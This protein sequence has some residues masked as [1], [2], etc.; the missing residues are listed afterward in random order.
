MNILMINLN[1]IGQG[2]YWRAFHLGRHL[3][4]NGHKITIMATSRSRRINIAEF[5]KNGITFVETPDIF[6]GS[7]RSG[8]DPWNTWQRIHWVDQ[9]DFDLVHGFE[10]RPTVIYPAL[11]LAN[12]QKIPLI[13]DWADWFG[14]GGSVEERPN[15][16]IRSILRPM[17][18]YFEEHFRNQAVGTTVICETLREKARSL[19]I[20]PATILLLPNGSDTENRQMIPLA[21]ARQRT[22]IPGGDSIIGYIGSIFQRDADLMIKAFEIV[23]EAVPDTHLLVI[24]KQTLDLKRLTKHPEAIIQTGYAPDH[25]LNDLLSAC[26][27]F[28]LPLC[29]SNA[30]RGRLPL[31]LND[32]FSSGRPTVASSVGDVPKVFS[33]GNVGLLSQANPDDFAKQTILLAQD[34]DLRETLGQQAR[35][36]AETCLNWRTLAA[37]LDGFYN[38]IRLHKGQTH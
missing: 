23:K 33:M 28:W 27:M 19:G 9:H 37:E 30:N 35:Q 11:R 22:G 5:L 6:S 20:E 36:I 3:S 15:P 13:L 17:E 18:T 7:L 10:S 8:W 1:M 12:Q 29:D 2:T 24:G 21:V 38:K 14:R 25:R 32:Y 34:R 16:V 31:K 26:D 4:R